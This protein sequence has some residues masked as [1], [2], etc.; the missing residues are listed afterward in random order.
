MVC[1]G[2][3]RQRSQRRKDLEIRVSLIRGGHLGL[4][5]R[6]DV[7]GNEPQFS[8]FG[9]LSIK[10]YSGD[11]ES[12]VG[13]GGGETSSKAVSHARAESHWKVRWVEDETS[14]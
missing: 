4:S 1:P 2:T 5:S 3:D 13:V 7:A 11:L 6:A 10:N 14:A 9:C 8:P 12:I